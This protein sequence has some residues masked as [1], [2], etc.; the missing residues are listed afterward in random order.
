MKANKAAS[1]TQAMFCFKIK[2]KKK[3]YCVYVGILILQTKMSILM[4]NIMIQTV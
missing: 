3:K 4:K 2:K 1:S